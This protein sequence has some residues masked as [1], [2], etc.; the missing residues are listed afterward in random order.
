MDSRVIPRQLEQS[1][2]RRLF[3]YKVTNTNDDCI[4]EL[5]WKFALLLG[6]EKEFV[7]C[8]V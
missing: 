4:E 6:A 1:D 7:E 2:F 3:M 5:S 8:V